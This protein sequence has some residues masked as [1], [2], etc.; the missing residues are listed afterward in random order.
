VPYWCSV[1]GITFNDCC[2]KPQ[3]ALQLLDGL[4]YMG[5]PKFYIQRSTA[6]YRPKRNLL[7]REREPGNRRALHC[8]SLRELL[9]VPVVSLF[10]GVEFQSSVCFSSRASYCLTK[11]CTCSESD[12]AGPRR[13]TGGSGTRPGLPALVRSPAV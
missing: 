6:K 12:P 7:W 8:D 3:S 13:A 9:V 2:L 11:S 5:A 4:Q 10:R 1:R